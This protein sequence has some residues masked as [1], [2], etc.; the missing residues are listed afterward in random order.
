MWDK[1]IIAGCGNVAKTSQSIWSLHIL[2]ILPI[3]KL[4]G[5]IRQVSNF[6]L[7]IWCFVYW[8][9]D[10]GTRFW[11]LLNFLCPIIVFVHFSLPSDQIWQLLSNPIKSFSG[12]FFRSSV[13]CLT[14]RWKDEWKNRE[15][16]QKVL[17]S[18][19]PQGPERSVREFSLVVAPRTSLAGLPSRVT[20]LPYA[21]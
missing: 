20:A 17:K 13:W 21:K 19:W 7:V 6:L 5:I 9:K 2:R 4:N 11:L 18:W 3:E 8:P 10:A 16:H 1:E 12:K 15:H 14:I